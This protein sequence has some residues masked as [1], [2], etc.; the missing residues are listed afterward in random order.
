[1]A[2][3]LTQK[4]FVPARQLSNDSIGEEQRRPLD[5]REYVRHSSVDDVIYESS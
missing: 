4:A 5:S 3:S 2:M 1:M